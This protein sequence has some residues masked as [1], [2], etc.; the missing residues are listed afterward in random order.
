MNRKKRILVAVDG[1]KDSM[2]AANYVAN[3]IEGKRDF[4]ICLLH[5]LGPIPP[6]L[7]EFGGSEDPRREEELEKELE[8]K[9][10][11]WIERSKT[12]A[13]PL[14]KKAK[15]IFRKSR[16]PAKAIDTQFWIDINR[17]GLA[18]D[19]LEAGRLNKCHTVVVGRESFSWLKEIFQRHVADELVRHAH[20]LT[21][22]VVE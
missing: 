17:E 13:L 8:N 18:S 4:T 15:S 7:T 16:L 12:K 19:I 5:V 11:Q 6:E 2:R 14:L 21:I 1:S 20:N 3:I 9:R 22:W 10:N